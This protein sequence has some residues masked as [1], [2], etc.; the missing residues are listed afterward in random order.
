MEELR[1]FINKNI[2]RPKDLDGKYIQGKVLVRFTV[3]TLGLVKNPTIVMSS[4]PFIR[5]EAIRVIKSLPKW[6][7]GTSDGKPLNVEMVIPITF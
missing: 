5:D 3:D 6:K 4:H 2:T 7:P 1:R